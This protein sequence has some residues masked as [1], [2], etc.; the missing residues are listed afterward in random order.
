MKIDILITQSFGPVEEIQKA[1]R[2]INREQTFFKLSMGNANWVGKYLK[3]KKGVDYDSVH[4]EKR[5]RLGDSPVIIITK[6][7]L[8]AD[9]LA[10]YDQ[11]FYIMTLD[12]WETDVRY[13]PLRALLIYYVAGICCSF[14]C[15]LPE[16]G[17]NEMY[18]TRRPIGCIS[19]LCPKGNPDI[20]L[21]MEKASICRKCSNIYLKYGCDRRALD[22]A[23]RMLEY[24]KEETARHTDDIPYDVF[25]SYNHAD[26]KFANKLVCDL[27]ENR[28]KV[29]RDE[30]ALL[31]GQGIATEV[32]NGI[33]KSRSLICILSPRSVQSKWVKTELDKAVY[34]A[35]E[36]DEE[37]ILVLPILIENCKIPSVIKE[38][39]CVN[40]QEDYDAALN[41]VLAAIRKH[42]KGIED[43]I[44]LSL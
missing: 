44:N 5:K 4:E 24:V 43:K 36:K 41:K 30:S 32:S 2:I 1:I 25:I 7:T 18:H 26:K 12:D 9:L 35:H 42:K 15:N 8:K 22:A 11:G 31:A 20:L 37:S 19:D 23:K 14:S 21:S 40:F 27:E 28:L 10:Y 34:Q 13:P 38:L 33:Q 16:A 17:H 29:W 6:E 39:N 3:S